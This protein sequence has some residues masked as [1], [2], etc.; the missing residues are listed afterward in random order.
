MAVYHVLKDGSRPKDITGHV[1]RLEDADPLYRLLDSLNL[2]KTS[3]KNTYE[4]KKNEVT[5]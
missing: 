3:K 2:K 5:V 1:I 4:R